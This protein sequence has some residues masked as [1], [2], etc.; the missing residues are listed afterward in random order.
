MRGF[1]MIGVSVLLVGTATSWAQTP[2]IQKKVEQKLDYLRKQQAKKDQATLEELLTQ[3]LNNNPDIRVAESKLREAEAELYRA[4]VTVLNRI[5][6]LQQELR[7]AK[8]EIDHAAGAYERMIELFKA[9]TIPEATANQEAG[10]L[11]K[12]KSELARV[13]AEM[14]LLV[15]KPNDKSASWLAIQAFQ[16]AAGA[17][18]NVRVWDFAGGKAVKPDEPEAPPAPVQGTTGE[19]IRKALDTPFKVGAGEQTVTADDV[20]RLLREF[21]KGINIIHNDRGKNREAKYQFT[22]PIPLGAFFQWAEDTFGWRFI[23]REYGIVVSD[24]DHVPPGSVPLLEFWR[25]PPP[26]TAAH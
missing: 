16:L 26:P 6:R 8:A 24:R 22:E 13:E 14:D 25:K 11:Q 19:R 21:A 12:A 9:G 4:R 7:I 2:E 1:A 17:D 5:V 3:A 20:V 23:I 10:K 18:K 15:G